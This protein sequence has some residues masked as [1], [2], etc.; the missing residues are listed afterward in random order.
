MHLRLSRR[1]LETGRHPVRCRSRG[2]AFFFVTSAVSHAA[3]EHQ[4]NLAVRLPLDPLLL[5]A[6]L[7]ILREGRW[8]CSRHCLVAFLV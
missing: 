8:A 6:A 3:G 4:R 2:I 1:D 7:S 5:G